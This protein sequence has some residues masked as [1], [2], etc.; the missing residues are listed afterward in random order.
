MISSNFFLSFQLANV[1]F[2]EWRL[3]CWRMYVAK[4]SLRV[5]WQLVKIAKRTWFITLFYQWQKGANRIKDFHWDFVE[6]INLYSWYI[7]KLPPSQVFFLFFTFKQWLFNKNDE[8]V[9]SQI[10]FFIVKKQPTQC[11]NCSRILKNSKT[12]NLLLPNSNLFLHLNLIERSI[13]I[14]D[15]LIEFLRLVYGILKKI[16]GCS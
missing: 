1:S 8:T 5:D 6:E 9:V 10:S 2:L 11:D 13:P 4:G 12:Y 3:F 16:S 7:L 14:I 15:L